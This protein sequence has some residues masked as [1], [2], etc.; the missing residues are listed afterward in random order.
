MPRVTERMDPAEK[1]IHDTLRRARQQRGLSQT[2]L[3]SRIGVRAQQLHKYEHSINRMSVGRFIKLC[4]AL[5]ADPGAMLG[6]AL[7]AERIRHAEPDA[8]Q[9]L[10]LSI[11]RTAAEL[12]PHLR[13]SLHAMANTLRSEHR[14]TTETETP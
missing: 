9:R 5:E 14:R 1:A 8:T 6:A 4:H 12:P 10:V 7:H 13:E 2:E 11:A 3:A